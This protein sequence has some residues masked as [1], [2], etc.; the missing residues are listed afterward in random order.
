[1]SYVDIRLTTWRNVT[2]TPMCIYNVR[3][4]SRFWQQQIQLYENRLLLNFTK[5][6]KE[7]MYSIGL[8]QNRLVTYNNY[9]QS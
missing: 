3:N 4:A 8:F 7:E 6:H 5:Y 1:M 2:Q 9:L